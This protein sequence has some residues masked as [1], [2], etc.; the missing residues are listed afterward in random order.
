M[1]NPEFLTTE[2]DA[3]AGNGLIRYLQDQSPDVLQR[4]ARAAGPDV[5][6]IIRHNV[7]GL[8]GMLPGE[9][10]DV[11]VQTSRDNLAGL[12]ASAM[13]TGYFLRQMEQRMELER[14]VFGTFGDED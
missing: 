4:V 6:E 1:F 13:M 3:I 14:S 9:Q 12:L 10:F 7:Q 8:L 11:K 5:Q 2:S